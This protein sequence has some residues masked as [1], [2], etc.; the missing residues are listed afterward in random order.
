M[1][2]FEILGGVLNIVQAIGVI[3]HHVQDHRSIKDVLEEAEARAKRIHSNIQHVNL[4]PDVESILSLFIE[5]TIAEFE[6]IHHQLLVIQE[7]VMNRTIARSVLTSPST[8]EQLKEIEQRLREK[9]HN[10]KVMGMIAKLDVDQRSSSND[11]RHGFSKVLTELDAHSNGVQPARSMFCHVC[12]RRY[13]KSKSLVLENQCR[14]ERWAE[15]IDLDDRLATG[16]AFYEGNRCIRKDFFKAARYLN[17]ALDAGHSE[18]NYYLGMLYRTGSGVQMCNETAFQF[19]EKGTRAKDPKAMAELAECYIFGIGV[20]VNGP[21]AV[22]H[23]KMASDAGDP[24]GMYWRGLQ[25]MYGCT[26]DRNLLTARQLAEKAIKKGCE[27]AKMILAVCY[28]HGLSVERNAL[29]AIELWT[30]LINAG[31]IECI[32]ELAPIYEHGL[33][34]DVDLHKAAEL[35]KMGSEHPTDQWKRQYYQAYYGMC[36]IRG[37]GVTRDVETGWSLIQSSAKSG[38]DSGW[39]MQGHCYRFGHGVRKNLALAVDRYRR[40]TNVVDATGARYLAHYELGTMYEAGEGIDQDY[41]KAF[42]NYNCSAFQL[43]PDAQWKVALW[44]ESGIG[45]EQN[46]HRAVDFF[47]MAANNGN[48]D[49]QIKSF[50]Y[51]MQ[52]HG[53]QRNLMTAAQIIQPAAESGDKRAKRLLRRLQLKNIGFRLFK[54]SR[55]SI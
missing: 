25:K 40:A 39:L 47:R 29:R 20:D 36:L 51:Y 4:L 2:G 10:I 32:E 43:N 44:C 23:A 50:K 16:I 38:K 41:S 54:S 52:G 21:L 12:Q 31:A 24:K 42:E 3:L 26:T 15:N 18:A 37:R 53:L 34:V 8:L 45:V 35:Y 7:K 13:S 27:N 22:A 49:A 55:M 19:F 30:E 48:R 11:M 17:A 28:H 33:G 14:E 1:S 6:A 9:E 46:N 5:E